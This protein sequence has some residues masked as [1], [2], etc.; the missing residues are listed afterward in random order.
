M[1]GF[2]IGL[3][4]ALLFLSAVTWFFSAPDLP[5]AEL[6][7]RYGSSASRFLVHKNGTRIHFRDQGPHD[8][9][10]LVLLHGSNASL[11]TWLPWVQRLDTKYR[12][13]SLDLPG[14]GLTGAT[15]DGDYTRA[16]HVRFLHQ[17]AHQLGLKKFALAGHSMGGAVALHFAAYYPDRVSHLILVDAAGLPP[18]PENSEPLG[19][20]LARLPVLNRLMRTITPRSL[21]SEGLHSSI[22]QKQI[23]TDRMIT[24]YWELA[25][26][27]GSRAATL[28][29]FQ[30]HDPS[31]TKDDLAKIKAP[32]L[33]LWGAE[34]KLI[35]TSAAH[36]FA[37]AIAGARLILYPNTGHLPHEEQA[38]LSA[39]DLRLFLHQD[40]E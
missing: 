11:H 20:K 22:S 30:L 40:H 29:R 16:G 1:R 4:A 9:P 15:S 3:G 6:E 13:I 24:R 2:L 14:H 38:D 27:E 21:F 7:N 25:R 32:T 34:D 23:I 28:Q 8:A 12:M 39:N 37:A 26:L 31:F 5:R 18:G 35:P 10:V 36:Q 17:F 19:F 33:I